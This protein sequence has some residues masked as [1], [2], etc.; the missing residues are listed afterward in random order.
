MEDEKN[1][2]YHQ[3]SDLRRQIDEEY[4]VQIEGFRQ[5]I[6]LLES[7]IQEYESSFTLVQ[8]QLREK[9][10]T[11]QRVTSLNTDVQAV[12]SSLPKNLSQPSSVSNLPQS[13]TSAL[14]S[15]DE[16]FIDKYSSL[17]KEKIFHKLQRT[18]REVLQQP[19]TNLRSNQ[20]FTHLKE[21]QVET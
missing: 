21:S 15:I 14:V 6:N 19:L 4:V 7:R 12:L 13:H 2:L 8:D 16:P 18:K 11:L 9:T 20:I 5:R 1:T 17:L 10:L 3:I